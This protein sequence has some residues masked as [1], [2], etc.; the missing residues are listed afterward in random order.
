[1]I[2]LGLG[3]ILILFWI[4]VIRLRTY[5]RNESKLD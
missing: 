5:R 4:L 2:L 1:M 3:I